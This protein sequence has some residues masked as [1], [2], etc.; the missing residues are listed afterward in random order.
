[1]RMAVCAHAPEYTARCSEKQNRFEW[2]MGL[3]E[4]LILREMRGGTEREGITEQGER[5]Q[6]DVY[7]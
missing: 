7:V 4:I 2:G 1:M 6:E 5:W 3:K